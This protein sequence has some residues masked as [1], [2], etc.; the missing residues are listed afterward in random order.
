M[1]KAKLKSTLKMLFFKFFQ[2]IFSTSHQKS[3][4]RHYIYFSKKE[5][6]LGAYPEGKFLTTEPLKSKNNCSDFRY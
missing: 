4:R 5:V 2:I 3:W 1:D 6:D